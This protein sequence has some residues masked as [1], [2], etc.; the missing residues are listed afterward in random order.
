M[1]AG[2]GREDE[3]GLVQSGALEVA[4]EARARPLHPAQPR[5]VARHR[6]GVLPVEV[7]ADLCPGAEPGPAGQVVVG[8]VARCAAVVGR[9]PRHGQQVRLVDD[10]QPGVSRRDPGHIPGLERR[11]DQDRYR[12]RCHLTSPSSRPAGVTG[13]AA[14]TPPPPPGRCRPRD[15]PSPKVIVDSQQVSSRGLDR[16]EPV[17]DR[18]APD[19]QPPDGQTTSASADRCHIATYLATRCDIDRIG[20]GWGGPLTGSLVSLW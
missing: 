14:R 3:A 4:A 16:Q 10:L 5:A 18:A 2:R 1:H 15:T 6:G 19:G 17:K 13:Q 11:R 12:A 7:E 9:V 8:Q 20:L